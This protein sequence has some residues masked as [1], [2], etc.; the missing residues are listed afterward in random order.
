MGMCILTHR[1]YKNIFICDA[2][3]LLGPRRPHDWGF[4][5][6]LRHTKL[7]RTPWT[8]DQPVTPFSA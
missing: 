4:E 6:T 7:G 1:I 5:V 3:S 8:S 2:T